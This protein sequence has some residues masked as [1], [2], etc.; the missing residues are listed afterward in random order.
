AERVAAGVTISRRDAQQG[1]QL[2]N[3]LLDMLAAEGAGTDLLRLRAVVPIGQREDGAFL[4][5]AP[6]RLAARLLEGRFQRPVE[7]ALSS[8]LEAP[9][10]IAVLNPDRWAIID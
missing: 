7:Q 1:E 6:T 10:H 2:W 5:G 4:L 9:V 3:A 8:L